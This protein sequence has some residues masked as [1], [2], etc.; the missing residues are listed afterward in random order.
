MN[1][2][3]EDNNIFFYPEQQDE[4]IDVNTLVI[5]HT[6]PEIFEMVIRW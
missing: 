4:M 3:I 5:A 6:S 1:K 2:S